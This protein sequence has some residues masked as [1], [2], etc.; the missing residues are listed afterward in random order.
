MKPLPHR[1]S[2]LP[3]I[4]PANL[5]RLLCYGASWAEEESPL[6]PNSRAVAYRTGALEAIAHLGACVITQDMTG[7]STDTGEVRDLISDFPSERVL[8]RRIE[9]HI[10]QVAK[11]RA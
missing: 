9:R 3:R 1:L 8:T 11:A 10:K 6:D 7:E 4:S 2:S 5:A